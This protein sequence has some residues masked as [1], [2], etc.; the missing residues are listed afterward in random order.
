MNLALPILS[1]A[2]ISAEKRKPCFGK[3]KQL[4]EL[5]TFFDL[6][7]KKEQTIIEIN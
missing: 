4:Q 5:V 7:I 1:D 3:P 6:H 2:P